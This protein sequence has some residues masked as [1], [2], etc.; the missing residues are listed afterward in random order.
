MDKLVEFEDMKVGM[1]E[2]MEM[3]L[4]LVQ[5]VRRLEAVKEKRIC[6]EE[7][8]WSPS[9][10]RTVRLKKKQAF[11]FAGGDGSEERLYVE[12]GL[13]SKGVVVEEELVASGSGVTNGEWMPVM[14]MAPTTPLVA[15]LN[16]LD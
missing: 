9:P 11:W 6:W 13:L 2:L 5:C 16:E 15:S 4:D 14:V 10:V 7:R 1:K 3:N 12:L 8:R